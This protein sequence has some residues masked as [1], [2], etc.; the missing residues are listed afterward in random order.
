M[1]R[2]TNT[3]ITNTKNNL[4]DPWSSELPED[5]DRIIKNF[6][7]ERFTIDSLPEP[8]VLMRRGIV[9]ASR[10]LKRIREAIINKKPYYVLTGIMPSS[11]KIHFGTKSVIDNVVYFQQHNARTFVC[12]ADLESL[13]TRKINLEE[14]RNRALE[15]HIPMY[16]ALGLDIKKTIFYFQSENK[17]VIHLAYDFSNRITLSEFRAVYGSA[18]PPR[19]MSALTQAG[20][21]LFPQLDE[22]MP[23]IIPVGVDQDPHIRLTRDIVARTK[24]RFNF[25]PPSSI[26]NKFLPSLSGSLKMSKSE[27]QSS[28]FLP[29]DPDDVC[30]KLKRA[31]TGGRESIKLQKEKGG[32]PSKCMI[33]EFLKQ[34]LVE[35]DKELKKILE[36]CKSGRLLCGECKQLTCEKARSFFERLNKRFEVMKNKVDNIKLIKFN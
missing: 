11:S 15:F 6:G 4:I 29:T 12:V 8:N 1:K 24:T 14:A 19:I 5:Y 33:F 13:A 30:K 3:R 7:L 16:L 21:I 22:K 23:G 31:L 20:D 2:I 9:F 26:Y 17:R 35:D 28:I 18:D 34:H 32:D 25:I 27:P 36:D 10:D